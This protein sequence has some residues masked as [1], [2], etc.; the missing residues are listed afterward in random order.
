MLATGGPPEKKPRLDPVED[1]A[2]YMYQSLICNWDSTVLFE[3]A[4]PNSIL[5]EAAKDINSKL[6]EVVALTRT[7]ATSEVS[8][9]TQQEIKA[10]KIRIAEEELLRVIAARETE[11]ELKLLEIE[12]ARYEVELAHLKLKEYKVNVVQL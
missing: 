9:A 2:P 11:K 12:R 8:I 10:L 7:I 5:E 3:Q 1:A 6:P 4:K